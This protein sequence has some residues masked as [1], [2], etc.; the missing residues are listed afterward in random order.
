MNDHDH[1][2]VYDAA[3]EDFLNECAAKHEDFVRSQNLP[4]ETAEP[5]PVVCPHCGG[6][7]S[8]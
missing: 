4:S 6:I 8:Q 3:T 1:D 5:L 2:H 7:V